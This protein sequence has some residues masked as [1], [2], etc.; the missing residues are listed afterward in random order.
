MPN[1]TKVINIFDRLTVLTGN[2]GTGK[3][4]KAV[5][6]AVNKLY[7]EGKKVLHITNEDRGSQIRARY[8][9]S[10]L[11]KEKGLNISDAQIFK[12][13]YESLPK[14]LINDFW[15]EML[16]KN[17]LGTLRIESTEDWEDSIKTIK[18]CLE[19]V[20]SNLIVFDQLFPTIEQGQ[21]YVDK[22]FNEIEELLLTYKDL[23]IILVIQS[24]KIPDEVIAGG[25]IEIITKNLRAIESNLLDIEAKKSVEDTFNK[26][27]EEAWFHLCHF[28]EMEIRMA[29]ELGK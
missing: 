25:N 4:R 21:E 11:H 15:L 23:E 14:Y 7:Y 12:E 27:R 20:Q 16:V 18:D 29:S 6:K 13:E 22:F 26:V 8:L 28:E 19:K 1:E 24:G 5:H 3:S 9:S 17:G 10:A 2:P